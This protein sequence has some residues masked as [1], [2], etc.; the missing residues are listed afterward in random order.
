M[1][2][3]PIQKNLTQRTFFFAK[4]FFYNQI[5]Y[6]KA[7]IR[8]EIGNPFLQQ[9]SLSKN[10]IIIDSL[11]LVIIKVLYDKWLTGYNRAFI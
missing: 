2:I 11:L 9:E 10:I 7:K 3:T 6:F 5:L 4:N 1:Q 8:P